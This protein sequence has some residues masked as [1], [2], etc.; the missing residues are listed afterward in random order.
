L[1]LSHPVQAERGRKRLNFLLKQAEVFQHFAPN[2]AAAGAE[3]KKKRGRHAA[4]YTEDQEDAELLK[5]EEGGS[6]AAGHR[7]SIQ[8][9]VISGGKMREYQLQGLNW[10]IHLYDNGINGILADE[11]V[12]GLR[13]LRVLKACGGKPQQLT[14]SKLARILVTILRPSG[15]LGLGTQMDQEPGWQR[16]LV[17]LPNWRS[18]PRYSD[19]MQPGWLRE[20]L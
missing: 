9:S 13:R 17:S 7:L 10:L 20:L 15:N 6:E 4:S 19:G 14:G 16:E 1:A 12:G 11:M 18:R 5:D 3:K 2:A 8:P